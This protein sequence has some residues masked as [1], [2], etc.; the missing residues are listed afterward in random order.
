MPDMKES[1]APDVSS[2][3]SLMSVSR[4]SLVSPPTGAGGPGDNHTRTLGTSL[5]V[6]LSC[7][8]VLSPNANAFNKANAALKKADGKYAS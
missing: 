7:H 2:P 5:L 8:S 4:V 6:T 3:R 1:L